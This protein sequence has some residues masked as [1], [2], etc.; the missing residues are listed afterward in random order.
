MPN[1]LQFNE[2]IGWATDDCGEWGHETR[3]DVFVRVPTNLAKKDIAKV[4]K[5]VTEE[6]AIDMGTTPDNV[7]YTLV[8]WPDNDGEY[9]Y[10]AGR[11]NGRLDLWG[12][13]VPERKKR[14]AA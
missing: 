10:R 7:G 5:W 2:I 4:E 1:L 14:R 6:L 3:Q 12:P 8:V 9:D 11:Q 13:Y